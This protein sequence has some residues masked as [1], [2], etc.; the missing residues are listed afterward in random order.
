VPPARHGQ[1]GADLR[2]RGKLFSHA[3]ANYASEKNSQTSLSLKMKWGNSY[4][5]I[6]IFFYDS[7]AAHAELEF[8]GQ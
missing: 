8:L 3:A 6:H 1:R 2:L 7:H 5:F 4:L